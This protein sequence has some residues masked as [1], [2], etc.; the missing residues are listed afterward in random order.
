MGAPFNSKSERSAILV[1]RPPS[2]SM[3]RAAFAILIGV[4]TSARAATP[5][6]AGPGADAHAPSGDSSGDRPAERADNGVSLQV[7]LGPSYFY[8]SWRPTHG[9][10]GASFDGWGTSLE[11]AIGKRIRPRLIVGVRWQLV[12]FVDPNERYSGTTY[13]AEESARF[14][15]LIAAFVDYYPKAHRG[16]HFGGAA[17]VMVATNLD[18]EYGA[19]ATGWGPALSAA[20]GYEV[21]LSSRWSVGALAHLSAY[22]YSVTEAGVS[23]VSQG[24]L[25]T[26]AVAFTWN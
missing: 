8:E 13:V 21:S 24:L 5:A 16:L 11:A 20:V 9:T 26:L 19:H 1:R 3:A 4:C 25:P 18:A 23:S 17:G 15:D 7:A 14:F 10:T 6:P 2:I 12:A 22:R